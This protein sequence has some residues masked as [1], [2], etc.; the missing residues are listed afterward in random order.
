MIVSGSSDKDDDDD[1]NNGSK[2][3]KKVKSKVKLSF[4]F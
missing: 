1:D 2:G 3:W 4:S